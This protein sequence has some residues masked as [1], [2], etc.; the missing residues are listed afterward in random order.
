[1]SLLNWFTIL[2]INITGSGNN[3]CHFSDDTVILV[4][5]NYCTLI[6]I[7]LKCVL[8][9]LTCNKPALVQITTRC[10]EATDLQLN[11]RKPSN[12]RPTLVGNNIVDHSG[13]VGASSLGA[14]CVPWQWL[15]HVE[16]RDANS[17]LIISCRFR[18]YNNGMQPN[19]NRVQLMYLS[20]KH[21][22]LE[23]FV[24]Y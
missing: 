3:G 2:K 24:M 13:V 19:P 23:N 8:M 11:Y 21:I 1:M 16:N 5:E 6:E 9:V 7:S 18:N 12:I 4:G 20:Y 10:R 17:Y 22:K 15:M 14:F